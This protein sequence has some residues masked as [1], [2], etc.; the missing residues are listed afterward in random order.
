[1]YKIDDLVS[2]RMLD[3]D[4]E[5]TNI[6]Y[7]THKYGPTYLGY[8]LF[9]ENKKIQIGVSCITCSRI[10]KDISGDVKIYSFN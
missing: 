6:Y 3:E 1:M 5:D 10:W 9:N 4:G 2:C 7:D 8:R